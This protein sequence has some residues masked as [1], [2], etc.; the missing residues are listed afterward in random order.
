[1]EPQTLLNYGQQ[2]YDLANYEMAIAQFEQAAQLTTPES[3]L[4]GEIQLWLANSYDV[5]GETTKAIALCQQLLNHSDPEICK[6]ADFLVNIF[7][8]PSL[9][10][11]TDVTSTLP[12]LSQIN[13]QI[14]RQIDRQTNSTLGANYKK[15]QTTQPLDPL[16]PSGTKIQNFLYIMLILVCLGLVWLW[17]FT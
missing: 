2:L 5:L 15:T 14:N 12:N 16:P 3:R 9:S 7:S 1:M 8:A 10:P 13:R 11:L 17:K 4:G 6:Q